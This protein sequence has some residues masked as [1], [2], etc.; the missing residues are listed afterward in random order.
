MKRMKIFCWI[1]AALLLV[2]CVPELYQW[3]PDG[4]W[5]TVLTNEG[6]HFADS[7]GS[8]M[9]PFISDVRVATWF[10]DSKRVLVSKRVHEKTWDALA[11]YLP[12]DK[13]K[14][15]IAAAQHVRELAITYDWSKPS[16][17]NW[18]TFLGVLL[19][20]EQDAG[21][22]LTAYKK[23]DWILGLYVRD[24]ADDLM[25]Q[26]VPQ[27]RW[28]DLSGL[29]QT[30]NFVQVYN[31]DTSGVTPGPTLMTA[32]DDVEELRVAP[33]G[34]AAA[35]VMQG[36]EDEISN[37]WVA[38]SDG[39]LPAQQISDRAA[40]YP[41]W[42]PDGRS[43]VFARAT[44]A[45]DAKVAQLGSLS[46]VNVMGD[47][48]K[49]L[50]EPAKPEDLVGLIYS[51]LTRVRCLKDGCILFATA[52]V[53][54]PATAPDMP[55]EMQLFALNF[56]K[57][58]TVSRVLPR[59]AFRAVGNNAQYFEVS[60][61]GAR[62]SI[63]DETGKVTLLE[64]ATGKVLEIQ[65]Y[66]VVTVAH[67]DGYLVTVPSWRSSDEL[68]LIAPDKSRKPRVIDWFIS[69]GHARTLS[70]SWPDGTIWHEDADSTTTP[71]TPP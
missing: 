63:P 59:S 9:K 57:Q 36:S 14:K 69:K 26:K 22:D 37:L 5:M 3:S 31:F 56:Q 18:P 64:L 70:G 29:S 4:K 51:P 1:A 35:I 45:A 39:S 8:L 20:Q 27:E 40:W 21:R 6:L 52:Q 62:V 33:T 68:T 53:T 60:P 41:D 49:L 67:S 42:A 61:D 19:K 24:H 2:G 48:G 11:P 25:K 38:A 58:A 16:T 43:I 46:R 66:P 28:K 12:Q 23:W 30:V 44:G 47:D 65:P 54:L 17:A 13:I 34:N 71:A 15:I 10:P 32:L 7:D 50:P 55:E